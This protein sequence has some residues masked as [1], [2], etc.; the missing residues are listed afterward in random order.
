VTESFGQRARLSHARTEAASIGIGFVPGDRAIQ[1]VATGP[2]LANE[3]PD[4]PLEAGVEGGWPTWSIPHG[5]G[6]EAG[7][8]RAEESAPGAAGAGC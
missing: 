1:K 4:R 2:R 8:L 3:N 5:Y 6:L 7:L